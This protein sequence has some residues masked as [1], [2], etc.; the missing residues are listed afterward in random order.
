MF[1]GSGAGIEEG[2]H[3]NA[4]Q[5]SV[6]AGLVAFPAWAQS[7]RIL[8]IAAITAL[9]EAVFHQIAFAGEVSLNRHISLAQQAILHAARLWDT[10][11]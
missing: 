7:Q 2:L 9:S 10:A 11:P 6:Q 1:T 8:E 5:T 4:L 3:G